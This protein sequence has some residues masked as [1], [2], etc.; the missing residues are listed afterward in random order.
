MKTIPPAE[1]REARERAAWRYLAVARALKQESG[2]REH[3]LRR[4][5]SGKAF[6]MRACIEAP[7]G[8]SRKQLYIL[9]HECAHVAL[10]H[11]GQKP[12]HVEE[13]EA[14][15]WAHSALRR[16]GIAVPRASTLA[17]RQYVADKIAQARKGGAQHIDPAALAFARGETS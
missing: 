5:L 15:M 3:K 7:E 2:V 13:F 12:R 11:M 10:T 16:H 8:R 1:L 9:A 17:A 14:E 4:T 6:P